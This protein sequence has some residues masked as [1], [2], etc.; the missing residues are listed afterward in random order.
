[1]ADVVINPFGVRS[2]SKSSADSSTILK[3]SGLISGNGTSFFNGWRSRHGNVF[4]AAALSTPREIQGAPSDVQSFGWC[5]ATSWWVVCLPARQEWSPSTELHDH[6]PARA[7]GCG[8]RLRWKK[9]RNVPFGRYPR[10][11][12]DR[13]WLFG[14]GW[15][16]IGH[17]RPWRGRAWRRERNMQ[18][19]LSRVF[20]GRWTILV[21]SDGGCVCLGGTQSGTGHLP[22]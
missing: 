18:V 21:D 16:C 5:D 8:S 4:D 11:G 3:F 20:L 10:A 1:M 13:Y 19:H 12:D 17:A 6:I 22:G 14:F 7:N 15:I 9:G 2:H